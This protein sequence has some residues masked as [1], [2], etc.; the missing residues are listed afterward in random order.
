MSRKL[1]LLLHV[2][3]FYLQYLLYLFKPQHVLCIFK[4]GTGLTTSYH[5]FTAL[6]SSFIIDCGKYL[7][8]EKCEIN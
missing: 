5:V 2:S 3:D 6:E 7:L 4:T 1:M 8:Y